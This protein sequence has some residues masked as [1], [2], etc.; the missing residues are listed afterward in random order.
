MDHRWVE[1]QGREGGRERDG[2]GA[3]D[4][5]AGFPRACSFM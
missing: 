5:A 4:E 1:L 3:R 2:D